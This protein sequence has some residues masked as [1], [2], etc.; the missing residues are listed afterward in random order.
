MIPDN[1]FSLNSLLTTMYAHK[2]HSHLIALISCSI[3][4]LSAEESDHV[5]WRQCVQLTN[6]SEPIESGMEQ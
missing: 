2:H 1:A 3:I 6:D 5:Y 4:K